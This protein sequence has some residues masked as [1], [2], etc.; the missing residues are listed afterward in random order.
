MIDPDQRAFEADIARAAFR[1]GQAEGRWR[2]IE[3]VWPFAFISVTARDHRQYVLRMNCA[4]YPQVP[5]TGGLWDMKTHQ[6]LAADLWPRGGGGRVA[7]V[8][9]TDWKRGS[10]LYLPCDRES[11]LGH[12]HWRR[13]VPW[14]IWRPADGIVQYLELVHEL[15]QSCGSAP[16]ARATA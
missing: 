13:Q 5:P 7:A 14:K 8:F 10:A 15:L 12:D 3:L 16:D 6:V 1:V 9:R 2:L 4:G 11:F